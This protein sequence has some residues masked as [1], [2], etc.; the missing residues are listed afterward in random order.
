[1]SYH[2]GRRDQLDV[3]YHDN[4]PGDDGKPLVWSAGDFDLKFHTPLPAGDL[5][6]G[7]GR[8]AANPLG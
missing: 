2:D 1:M 6:D 5:H 8:P 4:G 7:A 3:L